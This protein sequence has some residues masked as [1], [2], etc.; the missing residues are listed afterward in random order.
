VGTF[1][2]PT[3][4]GG[5]PAA[6]LQEHVLTQVQAF[7]RPE[8]F[9]RLDRVVPFNSL[10]ADAIGHIA[11]REVAAV[12]RRPGLRTRGVELAVDEESVAWLAERGVV[13]AVGARRLKRAVQDPLVA[14]GARH[15]AGRGQAASVAVS[16]DGDALRFDNQEPSTT[17]S[18]HDALRQHMVRLS[19]LRYVARCWMECSR[20]GEARHELGLVDR[21][22]A[23]KRFWADHQAALAR[24]NA[25]EPVRNAMGSLRDA[26]AGLEAVEDLVHEAW[27]AREAGNLDTLTDAV[28]DA[29]A[30][31]DESC[32]QLAGARL[33]HAD[34]IRLFFYP[35]EDDTVG[36]KRQLM[37]NYVE[38]A[39][40]MGWTVAWGEF[41][42]P[43]EKG[44][45]AVFLKRASRGP[46][47][48]VELDF[49]GPNAAT[50]LLGESG[51]HVLKHPSGP[52]RARVAATLGK[53]SPKDVPERR[54]RLYD[55]GRK[56]VVDVGTK[57][58]TTLHAQQHR[59]LRK[60]LDL[61]LVA[62]MLGD[63]L[64]RRIWK[65]YRG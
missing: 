12:A 35:I 51:A 4:F 11:T 65:G 28:G 2:R 64:G 31:L 20:A 53:H 29:A 18:H 40:A 22:M 41:R 7:F 54:F 30:A 55:P 36:W 43:S 62:V 49:E 39:V 56:Q 37:T 25:L 61:R 58:T 21:L 57:L 52:I 23:S 9:N 3:G 33:P 46:K 13:P 42:W 32:L 50:L 10:G 5:D 60:M 44:S 24:S 15:L 48:V 8:F 27:V 63:E 34:K 14:P 47:S 26:V 1:R 6:A 59:S 45:I 19:D 16:V 38:L 17:H